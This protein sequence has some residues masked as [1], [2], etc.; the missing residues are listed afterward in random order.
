MKK[1]LLIGAIV[2]SSFVFL[3]PDSEAFEEFIGYKECTYKHNGSTY[4]I[5]HTDPLLSCPSAPVPPDDTTP[6]PDGQKKTHAGCIFE[7][8]EVTYHHSEE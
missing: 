2:L 1:L 3:T 8:K 7:V 5:V 4:Y 6:D